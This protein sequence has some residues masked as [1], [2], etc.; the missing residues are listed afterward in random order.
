MSP[1]R[2]S[3][4]PEPENRAGD[5]S[6]TMDPLS[7]RQSRNSAPQ[8]DRPRLMYETVA[9]GTLTS[10]YVNDLT[11]S[12]T[13]DGV[14]NTYELDAALRQRER[15]RKGGGEEGPG[16]EE[17]TAIYH[18]AGG[19]DSP[20]WTEEGEA[21]TRSIGSMGGSLGALQTSNG[22]I[23]CQIADMHGDTIATADDDPEAKE[24]LST[25]Q[26]DEYGN[27]KQVGFLKG[28]SA[29]YGWLGAMGRRTQL[30]SG[31]IQMGARSYVPA[32]GRFLSP[33]PIEGGSANAYEYAAGDPIN[34]YDLMGTRV[35]SA[36]LRRRASDVRRVRRIGNRA[37][38][39]M[40]RA[41]RN[42]R[43]EAQV[44]ARLR[45]IAHVAFQRARS[46]FQKNPGWGG[47]CQKAFKKARQGTS[48]L[49]PLNSFHHAIDACGNAVFNAA[50]RDTKR[51][52]DQDRE[53]REAGG[54][55]IEE[56]IK[57]IDEAF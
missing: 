45:K 12:Q 33:D 41:A 10:Y 46:T 42:S 25:Q 14:T 9:D 27:P 21:W 38:R 23:T 32:L 3:L 44:T 53:E 7:G 40:T 2:V 56:G 30:S 19:S 4:L 47:A 51:E 48:G 1:C 11:R 17:G 18:Y 39:T 54:R 6:L 29:E 16:A 22:E 26:F 31:V 28:G 52:A 13:Q 15:V 50:T 55:E 34:N 8:W 57:N 36:K 24:L 43:N 35:T 20:A 49:R 37:K 5:F